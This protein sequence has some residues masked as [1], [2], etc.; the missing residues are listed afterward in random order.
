MVVTADIWTLSSAVYVRHQHA[1][2]AAVGKLFYSYETRRQKA[3][4]WL[5]TVTAQ[6]AIMQGTT[7]WR[8]S[9]T[10]CILHL[11]PT[12]CKQND[13]LARGTTCP[14]TV[15]DQ[16]SRISRKAVYMINHSA[17]ACFNFHLCYT[18]K[19][20]AKYWG[21]RKIECHILRG[22]L[23]NC[24]VRLLSQTSGCAYYV[25]SWRRYLVNNWIQKPGT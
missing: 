19:G 1:H 9:G 17:F 13:T 21:G 5:P 10:L 6:C 15:S 25:Q 12:F 20:H 14:P 22:N 4:C 8:Q 2:R 16:Y 24:F 18:L 7:A 11:Y 23:A 3:N